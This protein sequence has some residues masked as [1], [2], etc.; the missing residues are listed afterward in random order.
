MG[1]AEG[2]GGGCFLE[3]GKGA[4]LG[5]IVLDGVVDG[6]RAPVN[7]NVEEALAALAIGGLQ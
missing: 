1:E 5:L 4:A 6:A 3:K 2:K 7:G